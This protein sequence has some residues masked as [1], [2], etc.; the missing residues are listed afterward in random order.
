MP[1]GVATKA[2]ASTPRRSVTPWAAQGLLGHRRGDRVEHPRHDPGA[3]TDDGHVDAEVREH[4]RQ[5]DADEAVADDDGGARFA[6][7]HPPH[8][9]LRLAQGLEVEDPGEI[10]P[11]EGRVESAARGDD[12]AL[13]GDARLAGQT[14]PRGCRQSTAVTT[15][16]RGARRCRALG[17]VDAAS[18]RGSI[19]DR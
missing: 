12:Q 13:V 17:D 10:G 9:R 1:E 7:T 14:R 19:R 4:Q 16:P 6:S 8:E 3:A 2:S 18:S 15:V 5:L 11:L